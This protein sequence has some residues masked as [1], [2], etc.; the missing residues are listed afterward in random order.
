MRP[1]I[2]VNRRGRRVPSSRDLAVTFFSD[3]RS[4]S[5]DRPNTRGVLG[6]ARSG[7]KLTRWLN[8]TVAG[9]GSRRRLRLSPARIGFIRP[10]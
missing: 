3:C 8:V 9:P 10:G 5:T 7:C 1:D 2:S 6:Y 4:R